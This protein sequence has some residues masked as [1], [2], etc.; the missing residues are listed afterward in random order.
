MFGVST[1]ICTCGNF[2]NVTLKFSRKCPDCNFKKMKYIAAMKT[3]ARLNRGEK[4]KSWSNRARRGFITRCINV[5]LTDV[6]K[7]EQLMLNLEQREGNKRRSNHIRK[8]LQEK[9]DG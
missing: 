6:K 9:L 1:W 3:K 2:F 8:K 4:I 5:G 7:F